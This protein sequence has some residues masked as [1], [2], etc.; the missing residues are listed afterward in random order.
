MK[1]YF[2]PIL[3]A[4]VAVMG[5]AFSSC[6][7]SSDVGEMIVDYPV[8]KVFGVVTDL[9]E[10]DSEPTV[11]TSATV[12]FHA[13]WST[14]RV[15]IDMSGITIG[16]GSLPLIQLEEM[17][18]TLNSEGWC[19]SS[20]NSPVQKPTASSLSLIIRDFKVKWADRLGLSQVPVT[21]D[22]KLGYV[23]A[24]EMSFV[25]QGHYQVICS[26]QPMVLAGTT[27]STAPDDK[28]Y[29]QRKSIYAID[30][31][32]NDMTADITIYNA[33]FAASMPAG[34]SMNF[35]D[36]P[37]TI[38]D[39]GRKIKF[40]SAGFDPTM[41]GRPMPEFPILNLEGVLTIGQGLELQFDCNLRKMEMYHVDCKLSFLDFDGVVG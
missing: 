37:F 16:S 17:P 6:N 1:K 31:D 11:F 14:N 3:I 32:F 20:S 28:S 22:L 5:Y 24:M 34:M 10:P 30:F 40:E 27:K 39:E 25:I 8:Q 41:A 4:F 36:V 33:S 21:S 23:P 15:A 29:S 19:V 12:T 13:N 18:I 7:S 2:K 38:Q 35:L 9:D 26:N